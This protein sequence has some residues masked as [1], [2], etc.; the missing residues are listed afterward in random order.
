M[1]VIYVLTRSISGDLKY[2]SVIN[3]KRNGYFFT[4]IRFFIGIRFFEVKA[5]GRKLKAAV[6]NW[7]SP[8]FDTFSNLSKLIQLINKLTR[9]PSPNS[10]IR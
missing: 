2:L 8:S 6:L 10:K 4:K 9:H 7:V 1:F 5:E 3:L